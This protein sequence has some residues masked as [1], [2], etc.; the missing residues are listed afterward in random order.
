MD[1][2]NILKIIKQVSNEEITP[3]EAV[4]QS[5]NVSQHISDLKS[6]LRVYV[7]NTGLKTL[8]KYK[9]FK[10]NI[11]ELVVI[12][13]RPGTG[14]SAMMLQIAEYISRTENVLFFNIEMRP[15]T[16]WQ[17]IARM[18]A[19][20]DIERIDADQE[21][22]RQIKTEM[23]KLKFRV[24]NGATS[25]SDI[26]TKAR[27]VNKHY[28]L[29]LIVVDYIQIIPTQ[30]GR[31][32]TEEI[33]HIVSELRKLSEELNCTILTASQLNRN[34]ASRGRSN[35]RGYGDFTPGL[36]DL[37]ES[38]SI[39]KDA[40]VVFFLNRENIDTHI[41]RNETDIV[42]SKN[43]AGKIGKDQLLFSEIQTR[44]YDVENKPG[45]WA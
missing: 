8:D 13:A 22:Q 40:D 18:L 32:R 19:K 12:G 44:F 41:L 27:Q 26:Y 7:R 28:S 14:K 24:I 39:G 33:K 29:G 11:P 35:G 25:I 42:I 38:D 10:K 17:R 5:E 23:D 4:K 30:S 34:T 3:K 15:I 37:A 20:K 45:D 16:L 36:E 1:N 9:V 21:L 6:E 31:T 2:E 43:R